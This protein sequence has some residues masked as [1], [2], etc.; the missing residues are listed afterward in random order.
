MRPVWGSYGART[1][2]VRGSFGADVRL[3]S[4]QKRPSPFLPVFSQGRPF[5]GSARALFDHLVGPA[6]ASLGPFRPCLGPASPSWGPLRPC[7]GPAQLFASSAR[8]SSARLDRVLGP[9]LR[10]IGPAWAGFGRLG[11]SWSELD[12]CLARLANGH[13]TRRVGAARWSEMKLGT[14]RHGQERRAR[15]DRPPAQLSRAR[16][17]CDFAR[18]PHCMRVHLCVRAPARRPPAHQCTRAPARPSTLLWARARARRT[19]ARAPPARAPRAAC[20][21]KDRPRA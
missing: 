9:I 4:G 21:T 3:V 18:R 16:R 15:V 12:H 6:Q 17:P 14:E 13:G 20:A 2:L 8:P 19:C 5:W 10:V 7:L 11:Q 1:G